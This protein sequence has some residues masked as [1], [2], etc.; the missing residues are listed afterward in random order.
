MTQ[1]ADHFPQLLIVKKAG[2]ASLTQSYYQHDYSNFDQE[3]FLSDFKHKHLNFEYLNDNQSNVCAK[4]NRFLVHVDAIVKKH[5][6]L[7][8]L[9]KEDIKLQA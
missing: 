3:K 8:K 7:K 1:V 9:N 5:A 6:P 4:F 2:V